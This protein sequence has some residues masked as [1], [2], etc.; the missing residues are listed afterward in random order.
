MKKKKTQKSKHSKKKDKP[1][2]KPTEKKVPTTAKP[3]ALVGKESTEKT[4]HPVPTPSDP[5]DS[6]PGANDETLREVSAEDCDRTTDDE[7]PILTSNDEKFI[8]G[9]DLRKTQ[10]VRKYA[11][12]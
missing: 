2:S 8:R 7:E 4:P 9:C 11:E 6:N 10:S 5:K 1:A 3:D 12:R